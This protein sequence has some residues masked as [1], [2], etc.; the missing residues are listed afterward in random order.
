MS[1]RAVLTGM[2]IYDCRIYMCRLV[3]G[4]IESYRAV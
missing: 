1:H 4:C 3:W 2:G